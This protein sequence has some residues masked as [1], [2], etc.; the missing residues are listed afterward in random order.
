MCAFLSATG[1]QKKKIRRRR[2]RSRR[3]ERKRKKE[4]EEEEEKKKAN[5]SKF[6]ASLA[7][8]TSCRPVSSCQEKKNQ[9]TETVRLTKEGIQKY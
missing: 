3:K 8:I 7:Y 2:R 1:K 4:V 6:R 5:L 9:I